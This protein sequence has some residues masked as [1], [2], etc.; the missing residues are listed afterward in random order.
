LPP[1]ELF[2]PWPNGSSRGVC[3]RQAAEAVNGKALQAEWDVAIGDTLDVDCR[4]R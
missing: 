1:A 4:R 3:H 2:T